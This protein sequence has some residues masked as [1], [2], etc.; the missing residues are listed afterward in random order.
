[1]VAIQGALNV[2]DSQ[3]G[4]VLLVDSI[5]YAVWV[6]FLLAMVP[7]A[8]R[9]NV[10]VRADT[11]AVD[12]I[13]TELAKEQKTE[14]K[15]IEFPDLFFLLGVSLLVSA[16]A[17][18]ASI[19]IPQTAFLTSVTFAVIIATIAGILGALTTLGRLP[20]FKPPG[21]RNALYTG[22]PDRI[23][24]KFYR[25]GKG[26]ALYYIRIF[27]SGSPCFHYARDRQNF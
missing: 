16:I 6:M 12:E 11:S 8:H 27:H 17:R 24:G 25:T 19:Y 13:G 18:A 21:Q 15:K 9:F 23:Q 20:G 5:N 10:W 3:F 14:R 26:A 1:M 4:Y 2:P 7:F 22:S